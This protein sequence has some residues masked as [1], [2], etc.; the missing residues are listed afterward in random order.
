MISLQ[1]TLTACVPL[2]LDD[3]QRAHSRLFEEEHL[4][5]LA[6]RLLAFAREGVPSAFPL[7]HFAAECTPPLADTWAPFRESV[8]QWLA[9]EDKLSPPLLQRFADALV[10]AGCK[11]LLILLG[12][13]LTPASLT[14][15]RAIPPTRAR[16]LASANREHNPADHLTVSARALSKH[17]H[18]SPEAF[19]GG[20]VRGSVPEKNAR[21]VEVLNRILDNT[22]WWNVFGHF[23]H[24]L[25]YEARVPSGHGAR[26][27]FGGDEFIGFLEPF[28]EERCP[29]LEQEE[30]AAGPP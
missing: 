9:A 17:A 21:A 14:D 24:D 8:A 5:R 6:S 16:L 12:Q 3:F 18:R 1:S 27:G 29:S 25:V 4:A 7:P 19:W 15:A 26:W 28:D 20:E 11:R 30:D 13:R 10:A 23:A 2:L 22:T